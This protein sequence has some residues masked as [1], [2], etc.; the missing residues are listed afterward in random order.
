MLKYLAAPRSAGYTERGDCGLARTAT[1]DLFLILA[2][3]W[4][5]PARFSF[6]PTAYP[7]DGVNF[8]FGDGSVQSINNN[9]DPKV[10]QALCTRNGGE[11]VNE[12]AY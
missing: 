8:L 6:A 10:Y 3:S 9:I 7:I 12:G 11:I 2:G 5:L 4:N 1:P